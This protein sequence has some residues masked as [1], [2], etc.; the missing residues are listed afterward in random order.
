MQRIKDTDG[1]ELQVIVS[2]MHLSPEFGLTF[3]QIEKDGFH[4]DKKI[5]MLLSSDTSVGVVKSMGIGM[6]SYADTLEELQPDIMVI[7]VIVMKHSLWQQ[8]A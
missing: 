1:L 2:G 4:I 3:Q 8:L 6:V 5:E 7:L